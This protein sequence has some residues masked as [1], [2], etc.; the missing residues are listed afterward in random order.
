VDV[1]SGKFTMYSGTISGNTG[2]VSVSGTGSTF[3]M[4]D[5]IIHNNSGGGVDVTSGKF[6]M[7]GG[8]ISGNTSTIFGYGGGV[9]VVSHGTFTMSGG[10]I[11]GNT[12]TGNSGGGGVYVSASTFTMQG[13]SVIHGNTNTGRGGGVYVTDG[14]TSSRFTMED[15]ST[16]S[17]NTSSSGG[18]G[19][20]V[21]DVCS[22][23]MKDSSTIRGNVAAWGGGVC[24]GG[25][26]FYMRG[27]AVV[28]RDNDVYLI[29]DTYVDVMDTLSP[30]GGLSAKIV[31]PG[32]N[33]GDPVLRGYS[34][35]SLTQA[36]FEKFE[37]DV[38]NNAV[39]YIEKT[40]RVVSVSMV[41]SDHYSSLQEAV[42]SSGTNTRTTILLTGDII[43]LSGTI[44]IDNK[45][46]KLV[47]INGTTTIKRADTFTSEESYLFKLFNGANLTLEGGGSGEQLIIDGN[48]QSGQTTGSLIYIAGTS[49]VNGGT[50]TITD[51]VTLQNNASNKGGGVTVTHG[52]L[53][54][55]GGKISDNT[56]GSDGGG[57]FIKHGTF[58]MTGGV[59]ENN[60]ANTNGGGVNIGS[61][62][63]GCTFNFS[64]GEI[65]NNQVTAG[66]YGG[67]GVTV[68]NSSTFAMSGSAIMRGNKST[69]NGGG[70]SVQGGATFTKTGG[71]I[72]GMEA[73][74]LYTD[75]NGASHSLSNNAKDISSGH[76]VYV[77]ASKKRT[78]TA[79][80]EIPLDSSQAGVAGGWE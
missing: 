29:G 70:V 54:M 46:I 48:K 52:I 6:T 53:N 27:G 23:I 56:A 60:I 26:T 38:G 28:A 75:T 47:P 77:S 40:G 31:S 2:G 25:G 73:S 41:T 66:D 22:L 10:T 51:G 58:T 59:I 12:Y 43:T 50:L 63:G 42:D 72:Y 24:V 71:T 49:G 21:D 55:T 9:S 5:G 15:S 68:A 61:D 76:A 74:D 64:G 67:G 79:G 57:V 8:T 39:E 1:T 13:T 17:G 11:S 3:I 18:G 62:G 30:S 4:K 14:G 37:F 35:Y 32:K 33:A 78:S 69:N 20:Y 65:Q 44:T 34:S 7:S 80:P 19:V 45:F 16:I 36:D